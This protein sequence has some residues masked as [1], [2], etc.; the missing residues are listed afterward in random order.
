VEQGAEMVFQM[1]QYW[2]VAIDGIQI[3]LCLFILVYLIRIRRK[4]NKS[5]L[6]EA[7]RESKQSFNAQIFAQTIKQQVDQAFA[8]IADTIAVEQHRLEQVLPI[9]GY[10]DQACGTSQAPSRL[11]RSGGREISPIANNVSGG[12]PVHEQIQKL[13][14][15]GMSARQISEALKAPL[16]EVELVLSLGP[17]AGI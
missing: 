4:N 2:D 12:D 3:I 10:G 7:I 14:G 17:S 9:T 15:K 6:P 13:A 11:N 1:P 16:G 5:A 8:N